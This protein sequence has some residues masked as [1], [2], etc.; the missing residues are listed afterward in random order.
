[1]A[2]RPLT[3]NVTAARRALGAGWSEPDALAVSTWRNS[4]QLSH[5]DH[6]ESEITPEDFL[7]ETLP[8]RCCFSGKWDPQQR[9][10]DGGPKW[11][12]V[13]DCSQC[14]IWGQ[15]DASCH[16]GVEQCKVCGMDL[17]CPGTPPP[18]IG[19]A[20]VC[21]GSSRVG[22]GCNDV[23]KMGVCMM[24]DLNDCM[25]ACQRN[26]KCEA[27]VFYEAELKGS[28][29]LCGDLNNMVPTPHETTRIYSRVNAPAPPTPLDQKVKHYHTDSLPAPPPPSP[30]T[31]RASPP[32]PRPLVHLGWSSQQ[33]FE[34][35]FAAHVEFSVDSDLGYT[36]VSASTRFECCN[37]CGLTTGCQDFVYQHSSGEC[38][39]LPHAS[40]SKEI[41]RLPNP[42]VV[43]GSLVITTV[44]QETMKHG[45]CLF[46][47]ASGFTRGSLGVASAIASGTNKPILTRQ[48]CCDA[49]M[50][51]PK[52]GKLA[53]QPE[54]KECTLFMPLAEEYS[55]D[56]LI[57]GVL[58]GRFASIQGGASGLQGL[59]GGEED[60][61]A[62]LYNEM[63]A[64]QRDEFGEGLPMPPA[65]RLTTHTPPPFPPPRASELTR[66]L[67]SGISFVIFGLMMGGFA[68]C[69]YCFF[70]QDL[71]RL[72]G[73]RV[74][75]PGS[76]PLHKGGGGK[77]GSKGKGKG[78]GEM[79]SVTV[80]THAITQTKDVDSGDVA[81]CEDLI[82]LLSMLVEL[83]P[84]VLRETPKEEVLL[85]CRTSLPP[86]NKD[87]KN[88]RGGGGGGSKQRN[89]NGG[90]DENGSGHGGGAGGNDGW[91]LVTED[92][93]F[94]Q[95]VNTCQ[96]YRLIERPVK[97]DESQFEIAFKK[98]EERMGKRAAMERRQRLREENGTSG[99]D[100]DEED[101]DEEGEDVEAQA[102]SRS[103]RKNN[104]KSKGKSRGREDKRGL[105]AAEEDEDDEED[106][107]DARAE[108][109]ARAARAAA[110]A[111]E[112]AAAEAAARRKA[113]GKGGAKPS[114]G[115]ACAGAT[116]EETG[117]D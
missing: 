72:V 90:G 89:G 79:V 98:E 28:C 44:R 31:P 74:P 114:N 40:S 29:V 66:G 50:N 23:L 99:D 112:E 56:G 10:P 68:M 4:G 24:K 35:T 105:L 26:A 60:P 53:F 48:D 117:M 9:G 8:G 115:A 54:S 100:D 41:T 57:S 42:N 116:R 73:I 86:S 15:A 102:P 2:W 12:S 49:C 96:A 101:D 62:A 32:P 93:D 37:Q 111:A 67:L 19:G 70:S 85:Q 7:W 18:L 69:A 88:K 108:Q 83:F 75:P 109:A 81:D 110:K 14:Q 46:K 58:N 82:D 104:G 16:N 87:E 103:K 55:S 106:D 43:S 84:A 30:M 45:Q 22:E 80:M 5:G 21:A 11:V 65:L 92:S 91:L 113:K 77:K 34:C 39:L 78:K 3:L 27:V 6:D 20:K 51:D 38:L 17:Y 25:S 64:L 1:M 94:S 33:H 76:K 71:K 47:P 59:P 107:Y 97:F 61:E 63:N 52:C 36:T 95:V 13:Q